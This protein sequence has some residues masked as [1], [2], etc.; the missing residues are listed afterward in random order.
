LGSNL[1]Y[2]YLPFKLVDVERSK[3]RN[4]TNIDN[5]KSTSEYRHQHM[6]E[7]KEKDGQFLSPLLF[8]SLPQCDYNHNKKRWI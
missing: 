6:G 7:V 8:F 3:P 1:G 5:K 2:P 4:N